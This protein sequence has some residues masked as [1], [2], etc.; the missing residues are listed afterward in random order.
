MEKFANT[1]RLRMAIN[2]DDVDHT[3]ATTQALAAISDGIISSSTDS[4]YLNYASVQPNTNPLYVDLVASGRND[5]VPANTF[6]NK[7][8]SISDPRRAKYFTEFPVGSGTYKGGVYG[9]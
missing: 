4:A 3:Y 9:A 1:L 5:F 8:N 7:L 6:V 2:M